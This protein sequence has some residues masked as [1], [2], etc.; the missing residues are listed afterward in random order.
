MLS[1]FTTHT[2]THTR[3]KATLEDVVCVYYL[4]CGN[5][6]T[7]VCICSNLP[8]STENICTVLDTNNI[9]IK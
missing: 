1:V 4:D 3:H 6:I 7:G 9:S 8:N 5:G 2:H